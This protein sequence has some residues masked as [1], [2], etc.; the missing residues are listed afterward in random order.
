MVYSFTSHLLRARAQVIARVIHLLEASRAQVSRCF[1]GRT[2]T[3]E[4]EIGARTTAEV[5][6]AARRVPIVHLHRTSVCVRRVSIY[7]EV[8]IMRCAKEFRIF[9]AGTVYKCVRELLENTRDLDWDMRKSM[10]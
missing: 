3:F 10:L 1:R 2:Y 8:A 4:F 9:S 7:N 5:L 6:S